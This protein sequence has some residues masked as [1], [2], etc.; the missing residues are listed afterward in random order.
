MEISRPD[1]LRDVADLGLTLCEAKQILR[2]VA[3]IPGRAAAGETVAVSVSERPEDIERAI[4]A[5]LFKQ[6]VSDFVSSFAKARGTARPAPVA[7]PAYRAPDYPSAPAYQPPPQRS[8][9]D[10]RHKLPARA[11]PPIAYPPRL[12][13]H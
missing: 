2:P 10:P 13:D 9:P 6:V 7:A 3:Q 4:Y 5:D 12:G 1:N 11:R 8:E